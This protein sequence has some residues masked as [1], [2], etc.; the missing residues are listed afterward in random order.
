MSSNIKVKNI[1]YMLSYVYRTLRESGFENVAAEDFDNIHDLF[2]AILAHGV[3][4]QIKRGLHRD[5]APQTEPLGNLR[6]KICV[7]DSI[8]RQ[9]FAEKKMVCAF[10]DFLEDT[11]HNQILKRTLLL[12]L[13]QGTVK[14][15]NKKR[16]RKLLP[17]FSHVTDVLLAAIRW[18][19]LKYRRDNAAYRMLINICQFVAKGL[20]LRTDSGEYRLAK[21]L[22]DDQM[23]YLYE[24][25][26]LSY[27]QKE[28]SS[29]SPRAEYIEWDVAKGS[30]TRYLP[31]MKTDITMRNGRKILII[32]AKWHKRTM[33]TNNLY[34]NHTFISAHLYQIFAYVK[35]SDKKATGDVAGILLYAKTDEALTPDQDFFIGGNKIGVKTL[36]LNREWSEITDQLNSLCSWLSVDRGNQSIS[37]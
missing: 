29:F 3:G 6:G 17:Y 19:T 7:A 14:A 18:E 35:N 10:D 21:W 15:E 11:P 13:K 31:A 27:Y 4:N 37:C 2:A 28:H 33:W 36:D 8:K 32:D 22:N 5:Y 34:G 25:F 1:Y 26:V 16:L 9:T 23:Y 30:D 24:K 20:L 12:L